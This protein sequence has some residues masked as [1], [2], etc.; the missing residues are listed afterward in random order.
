VTTVDQGGI[1]YLVSGA[2][3][4][5]RHP[6][7]H[8]DWLVSS[9]CSLNCGIYSRITVNGDT[10]VIEAIDDQGRVRDRCIL[11]KPGSGISLGH[12]REAAVLYEGYSRK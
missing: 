6:C 2:G 1:V 7:G 12:Q 5:A 3:A 9:I 8:A 4:M 10:L 11:R